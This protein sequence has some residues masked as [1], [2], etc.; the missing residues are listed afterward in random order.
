MAEDPGILGDGRLFNRYC[1]PW[2]HDFGNL[3]R[4]AALRIN[5]SS[6]LYSPGQYLEMGRHRLPTSFVPRKLV[7]ELRY[8]LVAAPAAQR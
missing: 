1:R 5:D 4:V 3:L 6:A 2:L 7:Y 8:D